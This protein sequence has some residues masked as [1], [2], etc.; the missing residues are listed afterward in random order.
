MSY[1][2]RS[3]VDQAQ[4]MGNREP[5]EEVLKKTD[6]KPEVRSK[7]E[8]SQK[9]RMFMEKE[10]SLKPTENYQTFVQ[11]DRPYVSYVV[12][13]AKKYQLEQYKFWYPIVGNLPYKGFF[14]K[15]AATSEAKSFD[16]SKY[17]VIVRGVS[18]YSTLGWFKDPLLSSM[19]N[20]QEHDLVNLLIHES[21]HATMYFKSQA[22][23]NER[24]ATF[25]GQVGT[26]LF[27]KSQGPAGKETLKKIESE[28]HD[29]QLFSQF[30]SE[31][32]DS[33]KKWYQEAPRSESERP[34]RFQQIQARFHKEIAPKL[35]TKIYE[36][37]PKLELN[38][39]Q[40]LY[41]KTYIY[42]LDDFKKLY[43]LKGRSLSQFLI[44]CKSLEKEKDPSLAIKRHLDATQ[45]GS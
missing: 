15:N 30:I 29:E 16:Q 12:L 28:N 37:F 45:T 13:A 18:A 22:E 36:N 26:E 23:F 11:L 19:L 33:L 4:L 1:L 34:A 21:T 24:L 42:N 20:G 17:D 6:L 38:N 3:G 5:I 10:L 43:D 35:K 27:Y 44:F 14:D 39:A 41:M 32:V 31:E 8:L 25:V 7:L 9:V 2:V 40:L